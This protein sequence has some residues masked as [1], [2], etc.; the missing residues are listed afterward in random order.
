MIY[1]MFISEVI[2]MKNFFLWAVMTSFGKN[3]TYNACF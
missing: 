2:N 3:I 1:L